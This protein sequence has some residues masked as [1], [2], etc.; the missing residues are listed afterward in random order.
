[1]DMTNIVAV[2]SA[3]D[4]IPRYRDTPFGDLLNWH[5][6]R[7]PRPASTGTARLLVVM[8]MDHRK[9]LQI[10]PEFAYVIRTPG[11]NITDSEFAISYAIAVGGVRHIALIAHTDCGMANLDEKRDAFVEGLTAHGGWTAP[12]AGAHFDARVAHYHIGDPVNFALSES[13]RLDTLYP[14]VMVAPFLY[15]V[16]DDRLSMLLAKSDPQ[17]VST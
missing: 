5:N 4:I 17:R 8:C 7:A 3:A 15:R 6:L 13:R 16:E 14:P 9:E 2:D 10:P 11:A 12:D 1:M